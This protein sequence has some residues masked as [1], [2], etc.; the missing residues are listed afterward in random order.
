MGEDRKKKGGAG[1]K[2]VT[3]VLLAALVLGGSWAAAK[4][5]GNPGLD[6]VAKLLKLAGR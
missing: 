4:A 5:T 6:L 1:R 2:L 3:L